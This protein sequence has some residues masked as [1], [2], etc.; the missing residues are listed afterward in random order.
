M[1]V[2]ILQHT[3]PW[4]WM[5]LAALL[6]LGHLQSRTRVMSKARLFALP[7]AMVALSLYSLFAT[8]GATRLGF[9]AWLTG[10]ILA[11]LLYRSFRR[12]AGTGQVSDTRVYAIP[13]S[14]LP[15]ALILAIFITRY[16]VA[17]AIA[18]E[19]ALLEASPFVAIAGVT[20]GFLSCA[21]FARAHT[22][23]RAAKPGAAR[24]ASQGI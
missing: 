13:G 22:A 21:L 1:I 10:G 9:A 11:A 7:A 24:A 5:L 18:I 12:P 6:Y 20:Y 14:W 19:A 16:A 8:L 15:M 4:V 23:V 2:Q 3:P 17:V